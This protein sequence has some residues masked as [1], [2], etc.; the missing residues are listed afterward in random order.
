[1]VRKIHDNMNMKELTVSVGDGV[2]GLAVG[3][4]VGLI[5]TDGLVDKLGLLEGIW[6]GFSVWVGLIDTEGA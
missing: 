2:T 6:V 4:W 1:M 3:I 5:D